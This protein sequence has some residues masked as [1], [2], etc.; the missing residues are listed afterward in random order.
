MINNVLGVLS[1]KESQVL[2]PPQEWGRG[3]ADALTINELTRSNKEL[4]QFAFSAAHDIQEPLKVTLAYIQLLDKRYK[5]KLDDNADRIISSVL[6]NT[7][8]MQKLVQN[9]LKYSLVGEGKLQL[10]ELDS[11]EAI[12]S[13]VENLK[14]SIEES[15]THISYENCPV[16]NADEVQLTQLFQNLINNAVKFRKNGEAAR[17]H[18]SARQDNDQW[19]FSVRDNGIGIAPENM[20]NIFELFRRLHTQNEYTGSGIGLALCQRI[21]ESHRG[22]IWAESQPGEGTIMYFTIPGK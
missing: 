20:K 7:E 3:E 15:A 18:I 4:E 6:R 8:K 16:V 5:G 13:A 11:N 10:K 14:V 19:V 2:Y 17:I 22:K 1:G 9:L 21:V 12:K